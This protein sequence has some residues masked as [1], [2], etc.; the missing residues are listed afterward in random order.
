LQLQDYSTFIKAIFALLR[1]ILGDFDYPSLAAADT[2]LGPTYFVTFVFF[3]F[4][5]LL[6]ILFSAY[7]CVDT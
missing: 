3:V 1:L 7:C 4:F 2:T 5:V 6:V